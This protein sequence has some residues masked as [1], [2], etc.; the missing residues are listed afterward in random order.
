MLGQETTGSLPLRG[1][2]VWPRDA[3]DVRVVAPATAGL[4]GSDSN[5]GDGAEAPTHSLLDSLDALGGAATTGLPV[6]AT[7]VLGPWEELDIGGLLWDGTRLVAIHLDAAPLVRG[8]LGG[9][10]PPLPVQA[11]GLRV[12]EVE[13]T[14]GI[15]VV[16]VPDE[17]GA[18]VPSGQPPAPPL[19]S[20]DLGDREARWVSL[21]GRL[22]ARSDRPTLLVAG[23]R[24]PVEWRCD[25]EPISEA[26]TVSVTGVLVGESPRLVVPCGGIVPAPR[27][28]RMAASS[29]TGG[30]RLVV[31]ASTAGV[32][33]APPGTLPAALLLLAATTL[34]AGAGAARWASRTPPH[35]PEA[36]DA[37]AEGMEESAPPPT[38]TLVPLPRE[39]AP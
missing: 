10:L 19:A 34:V 30:P 23:A 1:Y 15:R 33:N 11:T 25:G 17:P 26:T 14:T 18:F 35:G 7:L 37:A 31:A 28:A 38:L 16:G 3:A 4:S 9:R 8:T 13:E 20:P 32:P 22:H 21:V 39:R 27:L 5:A 36:G 12:V 29:A 2:R 6:G 24:L